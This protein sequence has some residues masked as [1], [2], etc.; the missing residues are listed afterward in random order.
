MMDFPLDQKPLDE[1]ECRSWKVF[2]AQEVGWHISNNSGG[3]VLPGGLKDLLVGF[4][5]IHGLCASVYCYTALAVMDSVEVV[6]IS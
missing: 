5:D 1:I 3:M 2:E 4:L 6:D